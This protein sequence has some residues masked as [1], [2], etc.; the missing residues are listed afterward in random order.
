MN[1]K[2]KYLGFFRYLTNLLSLMLP[3]FKLYEIK[4]KWLKFAGISA[5]S[6]AKINGHSLF[7]GRGP[8]DIGKDTW[9]GPGC[10][11]YTDENAPIKIGNNCD[12]APEVSFVTGSHKISDDRRRAGTGMVNEI[13]IQDGCWIGARVTILGGVHIGKS[14]VIGAGALVIND[15]P[16]NSIAVGVPAKVIK[17]FSNE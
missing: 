3:V 6:G 4:R 9:V 1:G 10:H 5:S 2:H 13:I 15:I 8:V 7:Y 14:T 17:Q 11:F 12:I 16:E